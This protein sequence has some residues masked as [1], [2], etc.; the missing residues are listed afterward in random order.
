MR[1]RKRFSG[2]RC[3]EIGGNRLEFDL[4]QILRTRHP[5]IVV[6]SGRRGS[7]MASHHRFTHSRSADVEI[8]PEEWIPF[9]DTFSRQHQGWLASIIVG[10]ASNERTEAGDWHLQGI[11]SDHVG[12]RAEIYVSVARTDGGHLTHAV[13][14]PTKVVF[15]RNCEGAPEEL[16]ILS[17]DGMRTR[18]RFR[19]TAEASPD[20]IQQGLQHSDG[21]TRLRA[22]FSAE[23]AILPRL[24]A[25]ETEVHI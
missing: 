5:S 6:K 11:S 2:E 3:A 24:E 21:A 16:E 8:A 10:K 9:L 14:N 20:G 19:T 7:E 4:I 13:Q 25:R 22:Q 18:V 15:H 12:R 1:A 23:R 17:V